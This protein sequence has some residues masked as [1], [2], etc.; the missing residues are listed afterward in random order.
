MKVDSKCE[1]EGSTAEILCGLWQG[2]PMASS[3]S[4][5]LSMNSARNEDL[6][7]TTSE[8]RTLQQSCELGED[9]KLQTRTQLSQHHGLPS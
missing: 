3:Y 8:K 6:G 1:R 7:A 9:L 5:K 2:M 4:E